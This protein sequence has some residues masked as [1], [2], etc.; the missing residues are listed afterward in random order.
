MTRPAARHELA[1][2]IELTLR[3]VVL[4]RG[5]LEQACAEARTCGLASICVNGSRVAQAAH[6][7]DESEVK[8]T[9]AVGFP[10]GAG[11]PD[12]KR[13]ETEVAIDSGAHYIE[14]SA[15]LGQLKDGDE[16]GVLREFRDVVEAADERPVSVYLNTDLMTP[17]EIRRATRL[18]VEAGAKAVAVAGSLSPGSTVE[19]VKLV[20]EGAAED[21]GITVHLDRATLPEIISLLEAGATRF[22]LAHA[23]KLLEGLP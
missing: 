23:A 9:C 22:G 7:L 20:R 5:E 1:R 16:A 15:N 12:V 13:Y 10:L 17:E 2:L 4:T 21:F 19:A 6:C 14:V 11:D 18:A 8:V 3:S